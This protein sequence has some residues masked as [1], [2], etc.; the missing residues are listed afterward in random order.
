MKAG[1]TRSINL[2]LFMDETQPLNFS[3][4]AQNLTA[5][6][7]IQN[8][9]SLNIATETEVGKQFDFSW[10]AAGINIILNLGSKFSIIY[11]STN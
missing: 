3:I 4:A 10:V 2:Y 7:H 11:S 1:D 6:T 8:K 5:I 9:I